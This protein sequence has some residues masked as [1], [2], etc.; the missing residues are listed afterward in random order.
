M[1]EKYLVVGAGIAGSCIAR[2]LADDGY[3]V[4]VYEKEKFVS[5]SCLDQISGKYYKQFFGAHIFR[6]N[7]KY[8][9]DFLN[10]FGKFNTYQHKVLGFID[11]V[12]VPIPFNFNSINALFPK[13]KANKIIDLLLKK[14]GFGSNVTISELIDSDDNE[15][16]ELGNY[17]YEKVYKNY[18]QKQW[19][20]ESVDKS[21]LDTI[22]VRLNRDDRYFNCK[23]QGIPV[24]GFKC[25]I[26]NMLKH[27]LIKVY[28][29]K[30]FD[31]SYIKKYKKIFY[32]GCVDELMGYK[33][34][35]LPYRSLSF[36]FDV[37]GKSYDMRSAVVNYP[38]N[39]DFTRILYFN[40]LLPE[41]T[42]SKSCVCRESPVAHK[43]G[44]NTPFYPIK[45]KDTDAIYNKYL[46]DI[47]TNIIPIGRLGLYRYMDM[48]TTLKT[49][50]EIYDKIK[51]AL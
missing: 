23:Y 49:S 20:T 30:K 51:G 27:P 42:F 10:R 4:D 48:N 38:N 37:Y 45:N 17:I 24:N 22:P 19:G 26:E 1:K 29:N 50:F 46:C 36:D 16:S 25:L 34:G 21:V 7:D 6:T 14:Y 5:G 41:R 43:V 44:E 9:W 11:G 15:I 33:F 32:S 47:D 39:Y 8:I 18:T 35:K 12:F 2:R 28:K 40:K 3:S 31:L 13:K